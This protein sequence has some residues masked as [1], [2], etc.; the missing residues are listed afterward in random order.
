MVDT[1]NDVVIQSE[2]YKETTENLMRHME[3]LPEGET[4]I[5]IID[6]EPDHAYLAADWL[7]RKYDKGHFVVITKG[8]RNDDG[9]YS[10]ELDAIDLG[11]IGNIGTK[12]K[13]RS[14]FLV[15]LDLGSTSGV[16]VL[17]PLNKADVQNED[18]MF[19]ST[20]PDIGTILPDDFSRRYIVKPMD[21][22]EI[23]KLE[24][25]AALKE[26]VGPKVEM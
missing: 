1:I 15:D 17:R 19:Y 25:F 21:V 23:A 13:G 4:V 8:V 11:E 5:F 6:N 3:T 7:N 24:H 22:N 18:I 9:Y 16:S 20:D 10:V 14:A 12:Y 26:K 2:S